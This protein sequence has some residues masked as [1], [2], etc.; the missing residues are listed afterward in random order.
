M[1]TSAL[2]TELQASALNSVSPSGGAGGDSVE[3]DR[4][5]KSA[6]CV[7]VF[8]AEDTCGTHVGGSVWPDGLCPKGREGGSV[9]VCDGGGA[10]MHVPAV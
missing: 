6:G 1:I 7:G 3:L 8:H 10:S 9:C 4:G 5:L 2:P